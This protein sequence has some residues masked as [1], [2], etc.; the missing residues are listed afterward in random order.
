MQSNQPLAQFDVFADAIPQAPAA[1]TLQ[2]LFGIEVKQQET[3]PGVA[4]LVVGCVFA[5]TPTICNPQ[6]Y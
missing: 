5:I 3:T 2:T 1:G 6:S 4:R